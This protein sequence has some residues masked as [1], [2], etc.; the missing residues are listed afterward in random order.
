MVLSVNLRS[1][2]PKENQWTLI[3]GKKRINGV[4]YYFPLLTFECNITHEIWDL[5]TIKLIEAFR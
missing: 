3:S 2:V 5:F 4:L 1:H